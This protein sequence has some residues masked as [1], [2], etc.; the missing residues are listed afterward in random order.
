[1]I[2]DRRTPRHQCGYGSA[3]GSPERIT[4]SG[5]Q[6]NL[7]GCGTSATVEATT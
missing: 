4:R 1:M 5:D 6:W 7:S 3:N 2:V